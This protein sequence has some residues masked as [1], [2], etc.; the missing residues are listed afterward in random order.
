MKTILP[1]IVYPIVIFLGVFMHFEL[2]LLG[3][4]L[5]AATYIP[6]ILS[7]LIIIGLEHIIP[8]RSEWKP[9]V[10]DVK[11]DLTYLVVIQML[12]PKLL[13]LILV[14]ML[15]GPIQNSGFSVSGLWP[16]QWPIAIQLV[17][18]LISADF[19][20]YWLHRAAHENAF[21]W[22]F[23]AVHHAPQK[24]YSLN[25]GR[26]HFV[27]K[28]L[29]F[30]FDALPFM[31]LGVSE[32]TLALYMVFYSINGFFQH[33]NIKLQFGWLNYVISTAELHR[34]HHSKNV[35]ESNNNYG[36]NL[37]IWDILFGTW[38]LPK[39]SVV[40]SLGLTNVYYPVSFADQ[41]STP[42]NKGIQEQPLPPLSI[43]DIIKNT[44]LSLKMRKI[45]REVWNPLLKK[46]FAP[47]M[48]Q[49]QVLDDILSQHSKTEFGKDHDYSSIKSYEDFVNQVPIQTY[50]SLQP[51]I[52]KHEKGELGLTDKPPIMYAMTSGTTGDPKYI[53]ILSSTVKQLTKN[54]QLFS[55]LQHKQ[56]PTAFSGKL[57]GIMGSAVEGRRNSGRPYGS[58]SGLMYHSM[59]KYLKSKYV[60]PECVFSIED[61]ELKY[62]VIARIALA[63]K[64]ITYMNSANPTTFVKIQDVIK[65]NQSRLI[66]D[67]VNGEFHQ[68][69]K[70]PLA[71]AESLKD[72][73]QKDLKRAE[74]LEN[75]V[76]RYGQLNIA[77]SWPYLQLMATWKGG[78]CGFPLDKIR[79][80]LPHHTKIIDVGYISSEFR[81]TVP[82]STNDI[83]G[84]PL[85]N[86][87]F[88]EFVLRDDWENNIPNFKLLDECKLDKDYY[89]FITT[90]SGLARYQMNDIVRAVDYLNK[91]PLLA[92]CQKGKGLTNLTG[93]KLSEDHVLNMTKK[94]AVETKI[95]IP[96]FLMLA[97]E[98][99]F[100]YE[101]W[102]ETSS[103]KIDKSKIVEFAE[104]ILF[105][106][107]IEY[108]SKRLSGRLKQLSVNCLKQGFGDEY[109]KLKLQQGQRESQFKVM[110]LQYKKSLGISLSE[111]LTRD[112]A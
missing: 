104:N 102:L 65:K 22:R 44:I 84:V 78:S 95:Q 61:Y 86:E 39:K 112:V 73:F 105:D 5:I 108:K 100:C 26:F 107:N 56:V 68:F 4:S 111:D 77:N 25:V 58:V 36:N 110:Y 62:L 88:Y 7:T 70:L 103:Q 42:F 48:T 51:Y 37:I 98:E 57:L 92:F 17:L 29:Q 81:G 63:E 15:I 80:E 43:L 96:F 30:L 85:L 10:V 20:R 41:L 97:N 38:F 71:V 87:H 34:W 21:L 13:A 19:F 64:N 74:E 3:L 6:I 2:Q 66:Q 49:L 47:R 18:M 12:L 31:L 91:A 50:E 33:S 14:F 40:G 90:R 94:L 67:I 54:Q 101:L 79:S 1:K 83:G 89:V 16:H 93:E 109:K 46:T 82:T 23:H 8:A 72:Y 106:L 45:E 27:D 76:H 55:Y 32:G 60:L 35:A 59:P 53:P 75:L 52:E 99:E 24:L 11:N 9:N 28:S 69:N